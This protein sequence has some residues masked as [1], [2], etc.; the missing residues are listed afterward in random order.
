M[1]I[2]AASGLDHQIWARLL[3]QRHAPHGSQQ[4]FLLEIREWL[5]LSEP[6]HCWLA[7]DDDGE[8]VGFIDA[9]V[10]SFAE[11]APHGDTPYI[12][13][14]WVDPRHRRDGIAR[15]LVE[16]VEQ[17]AMKEGYDWLGSDAALSNGEAHAVHHAL[18]F[19]EVERLVV[20]G[21]KLG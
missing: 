6:M 12:E 3:A 2:R 18:G 8:P 17:W 11:G 21:K 5:E 20:F 10:R 13:D 9:R 4:E 16:A 14:I 15:L 19:D 7:L 1:I